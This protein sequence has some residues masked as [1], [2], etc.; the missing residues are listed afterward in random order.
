MMIRWLAII[1]SLWQECEQRIILQHGDS[2]MALAMRS[3]WFYC[4]N[5]R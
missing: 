5:Y 3:T 1:N 2:Y 4:G